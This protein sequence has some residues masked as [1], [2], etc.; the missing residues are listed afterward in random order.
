LAV[1]VFLFSLVMGIVGWIARFLRKKG[2]KDYIDVKFK[3][4]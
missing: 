2:K 4:K 1:I 3:V